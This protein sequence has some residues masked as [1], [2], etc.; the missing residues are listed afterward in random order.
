MDFSFRVDIDSPFIK[1]VVA[2]MVF[3][4]LLCM[5]ILSVFEQVQYLTMLANSFLSIQWCPMSRHGYESSFMA[6][7]VQDESPQV[8]FQEDE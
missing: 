8:R 1:A 2:V 5:F 6:K 3:P 7:T 4:T